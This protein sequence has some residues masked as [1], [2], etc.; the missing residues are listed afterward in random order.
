MFET[1][2]VKP[3]G[4]RPPMRQTSKD[5]VEVLAEYGLIYDSSLM[6]DERSYLTTHRAVA[7]C[8]CARGGT[9]TPEAGMRTF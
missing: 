5:T 8:K 1:R 9:L 7:L 6:D 3:K 4:Y 2:G